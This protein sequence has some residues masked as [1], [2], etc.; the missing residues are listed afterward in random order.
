MG[1]GVVFRRAQLPDSHSLHTHRREVAG[2]LLWIPMFGLQL[3]PRVSAVYFNGPRK[4]VWHS[5]LT[6]N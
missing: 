1:K 2:L 4:W 6:A 3:Q 5:E